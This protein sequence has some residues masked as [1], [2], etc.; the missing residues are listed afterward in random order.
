MIPFLDLKKQYQSI[1]DEVILSVTEVLDSGAYVLGPAVEKFESEFGAY[2]QCEFAVAMNSGTSALHMGLLAAGIGPG[3]EVITV[4]HTFVA[5]VSSILYTGAKPVFVDIDPHSYTLDPSLL[6]AAITSRTK[7]I[8]PVHLY[9]QPAGGALTTNDGSI[10]RKSKMLR[11]WGQEKK[12]HHVMVGYNARME[13]IQGSILSVK[14]KYIEAWTEARRNIANLYNERLNGLTKVVLPKSFEDR[15]HVYHIYCVLVEDREK[16]MKFMADEGVGT[17]IHYP[18]PVHLL[19]GYSFLGYSKGQ[20]PV[21]ER[22]ANQCVSIPM[23]PEMTSE[24]IDA[25]VAALWKYENEC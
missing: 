8:V 11:D 9:G 14:M 22:V 16:F 20:F 3:D 19:E 25:V 23:Y 1:R 10:A 5:T 2:T 4:P 12:Y 17:G 24:M 6:E 18:F 13:G 7:A 21:S 15:R